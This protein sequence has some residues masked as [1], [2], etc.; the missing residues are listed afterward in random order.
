MGLSEW[1][2]SY[3]Y[4]FRYGFGVGKEICFLRNLRL[5]PFV[6]LGFEEI[7]N[8]DDDDSKLK[9]KSLYAHPGVMF[10]LNLK[11]NI[12]LTWQLSYYYMDFPIT[13][14]DEKEVQINNAI[15]W[16]QAW[17]RGGVS[18]TFGIRFEI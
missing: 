18:N 2:Q 9:L 15:Q 17:N 1:I 8:M 14:I 3:N 5:Q 10:G 12:Q 11:H 7:S 13:N 4:F 16:G 6:G